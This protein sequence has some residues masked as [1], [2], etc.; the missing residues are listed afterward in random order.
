MH[1]TN[2]N[3][4]NWGKNLYNWVMHWA[5]TPY[6]IWALLLLALAESSFFPIPP[7]VLLIALALSIPRKSYYYAAVCSI[8]SVIGAIIGYAIGYYFWE[9]IGEGIIDFYH[10]QE[11]FDK[12]K[13]AYQQNA[14]IAVFTAAFTPI[15]FKVFTIAGG[16]CK[17]DL[18]KDLVLASSIGRSMRFFLVA[19]LFYFFGPPIKQFIDK[20]FQLL[21]IIF[22]IL[23]IG[24][25]VLL[26]YI[27]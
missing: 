24:G 27:F 25:F 10:A 16:I 4:L 15:P 12:V 21:T 14:F 18:W 2:K 20:Y 17:I 22:T 8:G 5:W 1:P 3:P 9:A 23:L 19:S 7:D 13:H 11:A 26:K 6:A